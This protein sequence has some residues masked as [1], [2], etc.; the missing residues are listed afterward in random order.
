MLLASVL[1]AL[2]VATPVATADPNKSVTISSSKAVVVY[3]H[4]VTL[5][6]KITPPATNQ[7]VD[8][9]AQ[10]FGLSTMSAFTTTETTNGGQWT[11]DVKPTIETLY[12]ARWN[13][14]TSQAVT[15]KVRPALTLTLVRVQGR[16][17][18]F[19]VTALGARPFAGKFV[20]VQ[21]VT[22]LG[23]ATLKKITLN[24]ESKA[25]FKVR[26]KKRHIRLRVVMPT[27]QAA[28]GYIAGFSNVLMVRR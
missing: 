25:T 7:K 22:N 19:A 21:R 1:A 18:T 27:S 16:I 10:P 6:G 12:Q 3:G 9:L 17:G 4:A 20:N 15:V 11:L 2:L 5:S 24:T 26:L 8:V 28:P 23:A 14:E 13:S